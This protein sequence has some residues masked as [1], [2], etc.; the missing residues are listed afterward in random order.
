MGIESD[1]FVGQ[2]LAGS[3]L[4][5]RGDKRL[6]IHG[7]WYQRP[8]QKQEL[9][10]A[11]ASLPRQR[12][13]PTSDYIVPDTIRNTDITTL[14]ITMSVC[15]DEHRAPVYHS[16]SQDMQIWILRQADPPRRTDLSLRNPA[17]AAGHHDGASTSL[18]E[19]AVLPL[20]FLP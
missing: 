7:S 11:A 13:S 18:Q 20:G 16:H 4:A 8:R 12:F 5:A 10:A 14:V 19:G 3:W 1:P 6:H 15:F 2:R 9:S 17:D